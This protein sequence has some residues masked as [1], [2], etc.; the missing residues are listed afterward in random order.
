MQAFNTLLTS[1]VKLISLLLL[2]SLFSTAS[3]AQCGD[4]IP[5]ISSV[6]TFPY[7]ERFEN[8]PGGWFHGKIQNNFP[9]P[10]A[11]P[12]PAPYFPGFAVSDTW[13]FGTPNKTFITGAASGDSCWVVGGLTGN[14]PN[15]EHSFVASP[16]FDFSTLN[17]PFIALQVNYDTE[18]SIDGAVI[19]VSTDSGKTWTRLGTTGGGVNWYNRRTLFASPGRLCTPANGQGWGGR[20]NGWRRAQVDASF[21]GGLPNVM[22]RVVF[23]SDFLTN[24]GGFAFDDFT[25]VERSAANLGQ[26]TALCF[27][28][29]V[30][31]DLGNV[32][33]ATYIWDNNDSTQVR[34]TVTPNPFGFPQQIWGC[35]T[36][37]LGF[38]YCDTV[39]INSS[40]IQ[41]P[42][43]DDSIFCPGDS[44]IYNLRNSGVGVNANYRWYVFDSLSNSFVQTSTMRDLVTDTSGL[45]RYEIFD[46]LGCRIT[47]TLETIKEFVPDVDIGED[48]TV[49]VGTA[50]ILSAPNGPPGTRYDWRLNAI[51]NPFANTQTIFA[52]APGQ[53]KVTLTTP[54]GCLNSDSMNL[55]VILAPV[56]DLG[57]DRPEC[58]SVTLSAGNPGAS[59]LWS[60]GDTTR[61]IRIDPP[62]L[63][64]A[65]VTNSLGCSALD[66][67]R[68]TRGIDP[69]VDLGPDQV[70][71]NARTVTL[72]AGPQSPGAVIKWSNGPFG[73]IQTVTDPGFYFVTVIDS[74]GCVGSDSITLTIS[75]LSVDL[76]PDTVIC[77][78]KSIVL[79]AEF[80]GANY[81]WSNNATTPQIT[82]SS[83]GTYQVELTDSLGCVQKDT[84]VVNQRPPYVGN[85][86]LFPAQAVPFGDPITFTATNIPPGTNYFKWLF[87]DGKSALGQTVSYTYT[88]LDTFDV[89]LVISD[90]QCTDTACGWAGTYLVFTDLEQEL[91]MQLGVFPNPTED[92]LYLSARLQQASPLRMGIWNL[93]GKMVREERWDQAINFDRKID[94]QALPAGVYFLRIQS[95]KGTL[96]RKV[97]KR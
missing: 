1:F 90:G 23:A 73:Q 80:P 97:I 78:G 63:G 53:Y 51:T 2:L 89:C 65:R 75:R 19:Q 62:F 11:I 91:G 40:L 82:I 69:V 72:N 56:V 58:D 50:L 42:A 12:N 39:L 64:W 16:C 30:N 6:S 71:C 45:F 14:Y 41:K 27:G 88:S 81:L 83:G 94:L 87:G 32:V 3:Q 43:L 34:T 18:T 22:F 74:N 47:D 60:T 24:F 79:D 17:N 4:T 36:D 84:I 33:G 77:D 20:T 70:V 48:D 95:Q 29:R 9:N 8:G 93:Q 61:N 21:L 67:I 92:F 44:V 52:S 57:R 38:T 68:I 96:S 7:Q 86:G 55:E 25:I 15:Q 35:L 28:Q 66:T 49:C 37:T 10:A 13:A 46:N 54:G 76:G 26:D 59:Y 5:C 31:Y 85:F